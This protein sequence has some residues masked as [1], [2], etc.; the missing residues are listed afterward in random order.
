MST[1]EAK[2]K[3]CRVYAEAHSSERFATN[4]HGQVSTSK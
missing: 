4:F 2:A 3:F 1:D